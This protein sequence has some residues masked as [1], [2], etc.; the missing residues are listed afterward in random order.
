MYDYKEGKTVIL[1]TKE[2][3]EPRDTYGNIAPDYSYP[4]ITIELY[5]DSASKGVMD[6][7]P[8][9][10]I[11][12]KNGAENFAFGD[13]ELYK[14]AGGDN[15][16]YTYKLY[17]VMGDEAS[18][19][20]TSTE[21]EMTKTVNG[22][23]ALIKAGFVNILSQEIT[24]LSGTK[25]FILLKDKDGK[26]IEDRKYEDIT[27]YLLQNGKRVDLDG[28]GKED[29]VTITDGAK[30]NGGTVVF[31]FRDLPKYDL[32]TGNAYAYTVEEADAGSYESSI[33]YRDEEVSIVNIPKE[34]EFEIRGTKTWLDP[35]GAKRPDVT[36]ELYRDGKL[37]RETKLDENNTFRF[38]G[39]YEYNLGY[40]NDENDNV[41]TADGHRFVYEVKEK[42]A[43]GYDVTIEG[44]GAGMVIKDQVAEVKITNRIKQEYIQI[45]GRKYWDDRGDSSR[46]PP[47]T[48]NLYATDTTGR[49]DELTDTYVIPNTKNSYEFGTAGRRQL[50]R[51]DVNGKEITY[52]VEEAELPGYVSKQRGND[53]TNT[54]SK[55][56][57]SKLEATTRE[58][59]PGAVLAVVRKSDNKEIERWISGSEPH[60]IEAL[61]L[62]EV[63]TLVEIS[64][65]EGYVKAAPVD[66]QVGLN[67]VDQKVEMY[68]DPIL[69]SV[70]LTKLDAETREK[71]SGAEF[72]LYSQDGTRLY[73]TG[74]TGAY[75]YS[76]NGNGTNELAVN[77][78]G[79]LRV[80]ELPYGSYY[81][82]ETK[83]PEGYELKTETIGFTIGE[84]GAEVNVSF[85]D[86]RL[87]GSVTL[88]KVG[89]GGG[90][91]LSGAVFE[92][93]SK[94][95]RT[96]GQAAASTVFS[97]AYYRYG[98]YTTDSDGRIY[99]GDLPWD[100]YYF[101]ETE[102]PEGYDVNRDLSGDPIVYTF[103]VDAQSAGTVTI[104]LGEI[105]DPEKERESGVAGVRAP[106]AE[107]VSGVLGVR[108]AP[109][110]GVLG[111]RVGPATGDASAI[112]L[113]LG[114]LI[115]CIGTIVWLIAGRKRKKS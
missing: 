8:L 4:D 67:G 22:R 81:F 104:N 34:E 38:S 98:T 90:G 64:A 58:E 25:S 2:W 69:G 54:P 60:Y 56:H 113:W 83:A 42:G 106:V 105:S 5:R 73:V 111:T 53:F 115:A 99:V 33:V 70:V 76:K 59:L 48:V 75:T 6:K 68:D 10:S 35:E 108:S 19:Q 57:V 24:K 109:K 14:T 94:T 93:Y 9:R 112:A 95:P 52:R 18:G 41:A 15:Y 51:Y 74:S 36:I 91:A 96:S 55:I 29:S 20:Y 79:E 28:D 65:P 92:L 82:K 77:A 84:Q 88:T 44:S 89:E 21:L 13:L 62:G 100:D 49:N 16:E 32:A 110:K 37:Y 1:G 40:G 63:Y 80:D 43:T 45:T 103:T 30:G 26:L 86:P 3:I 78:Q 85:T 46:R 61:D 97:D 102:A 12:L 101:I 31:E 114:L 87:P 27:I 11:T 47:V 72:A 39:L 7:T 23:E 66:F 107:K 17:E 71:L 50:A